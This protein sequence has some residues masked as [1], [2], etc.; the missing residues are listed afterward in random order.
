MAELKE[1]IRECEEGMKAGERLE[2]FALVMVTSR[3]AR[4]HHTYA[5]DFA[6]E[7]A[8]LATMVKSQL[9]LAMDLL[10]S[11]DDGPDDDGPDGP[12]DGERV[13]GGGS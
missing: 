2:S 6:D 13:G 1:T 11:E 10:D 12:D 5:L 4:M 3:G 7:D 8:L 9:S